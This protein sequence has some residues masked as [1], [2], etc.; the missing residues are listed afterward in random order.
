MPPLETA[1]HD[2]EKNDQHELFL[3][4]DDLAATLKD[5]KSKQVTVSEMSEQRWGRLA[6]LTLPRG[7]NVGIYE[8]KHPSPLKPKS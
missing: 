1:F 3:M 5:L 7:G 2:S 4:C 8:P 6:T